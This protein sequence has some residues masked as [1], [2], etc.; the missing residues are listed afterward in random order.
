MKTG[1]FRTLR[2]LPPG[3]SNAIGKTRKTQKSPLKDFF[4]TRKTK[5]R[6]WFPKAAKTCCPCIERELVSHLQVYY[7]PPP[8]VF[9]HKSITNPSN[10]D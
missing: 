7:N 9:H 2:V 5:E 4:D 6:L 1:G 10:V 8:G 3:G